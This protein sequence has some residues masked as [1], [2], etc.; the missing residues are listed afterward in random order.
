MQ[1]K[2]QKRQNQP[3]YR[4]KPGARIAWASLL[5]TGLLVF[6]VLSF[7]IGVSAAAE[8]V[9]Y[10][11]VTVQAGDTLW[12]IASRSESAENRDVRAIIYD[13]RELN[14][15]TSSDIKPGQVLKLP[16]Q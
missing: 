5:L 13:I 8:E 4:L 15:L 14:G 10:P 3:R 16:R 1:L 2:G 12:R 7:R 9:T 6:L 11:T